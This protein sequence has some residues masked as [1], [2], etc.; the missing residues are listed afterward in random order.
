MTV[1]RLGSSTFVLVLEGSNKYLYLSTFTNTC[2]SRQY[3]YV[4]VHV[5]ISFLGVNNII[6]DCCA[7]LWNYNITDKSPL[8]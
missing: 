8:I 7:N 1:G 2:T 3:F 4:H 5:I 6:T